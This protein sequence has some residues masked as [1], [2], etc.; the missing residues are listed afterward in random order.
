VYRYARGDEFVVILPNSDRAE[1][2]Q[3]AEKMRTGLAD[4]VFDVD[5]SPERIT[6]SIGVAT[7]PDHGSGYQGVLEAANAAKNEAKRTRNA[8]VM[9]VKKSM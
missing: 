4:E 1:A 6:V 8:V 9:A 5:G 3:F 2:G 7:W